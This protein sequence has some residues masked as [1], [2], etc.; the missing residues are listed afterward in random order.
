MKQVC[1]F[2]VFHIVTHYYS[3]SHQVAW[4]VALSVCHT[5]EPCKNGWN[6][7]FAA[8]VVHSG[9]PKDAQIHS[10]SPSGASVPSW[11]DTLPP[12]GEYDWHIRLQRRCALCRT[13]CYLWTCLLRQLHR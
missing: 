6:D 13:T 4:S 7:P 2:A 10:Y 9:G 8:S 11:E 3:T 5:S 12:V 1:G